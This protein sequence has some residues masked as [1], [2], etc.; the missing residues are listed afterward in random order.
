MATAAARCRFGALD[1]DV[2]IGF[3]SGYFRV[4]L[5]ARD[6]RPAHVGD[7]LVL[8]AHFFQGEAHDFEPHLVHVVGAGGAHA[9]GN[10]F[11]FLHDLLHRELADDSAQMAFHH[12]AD[13]AFALLGPLGQE[14]LRCCADR[15]RVGLHFDLGDR[16]DGDGDALLGVKAL[17]RSDVKRHQLQRELAALLDHRKDDRAAAF[18]DA[19]PAKA[20]NDQC[21]VRSRFPEHLGQDSHDQEEPREPA[22]RLRPRSVGNPN[23]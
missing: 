20:V 9:I 14:L 15:L 5:D 21:F 2:A 19:G 6:V 3:G 22:A 10:H 8:V 13:Q 12:Q 18:Y 16:F 1:G 17:L 4:A 11:R 7:V 23:I